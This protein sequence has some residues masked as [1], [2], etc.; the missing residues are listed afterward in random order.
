M[1]QPIEWFY[2][3]RL[4]L[5]LHLKGRTVFNLLKELKPKEIRFFPEQLVFDWEQEILKRTVV[6]QRMRQW[7]TWLSWYHTMS[8][9]PDPSLDQLFD[10]PICATSWKRQDFDSNIYKFDIL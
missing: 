8:S 7:L 10:A 2:G 5:N 6:Y 9:N 4:P 1:K 3:L